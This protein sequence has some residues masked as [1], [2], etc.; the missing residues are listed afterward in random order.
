MIKFFRKIRQ[1]LLSEGKTGAYLKYAFGEIVLVVIGIL[2]ALQISNWNEDKKEQ[3]FEREILEQIRANLI[4]ER[5]TLIRIQGN[6]EKAMAATEKI[7]TASWTQQ[8][9][10]SAQYWL[11]YVV[12]FDRFQPLTNAYEVAKSK[13]L[14]LIT[15]KQLRFQIGAYY[16]DELIAV[17]QS[18]ED[19]ERAF[20]RDWVHILKQEA[21]EVNFKQSIVLKDVTVLQGDAEPANI[22]RLNR[23]NFSGGHQRILRIIERID[24]I[25][26]LI[27][28]ELNN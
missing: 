11:G 8:D 13:G 26:T 12:M 23:G 1:N 20:R 9:Q 19:I 21:L 24:A 16:D 27:N 5:L 3:V 10:D 14:D 4:K 25:I 6:F 22:L 15:N 17:R 7:L 28:Q 18:I 2:I